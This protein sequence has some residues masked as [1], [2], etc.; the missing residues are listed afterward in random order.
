VYTIFFVRELSQ[1]FQCSCFYYTSR[2][3][4][5][6]KYQTANEPLIEQ[7]SL[8]RYSYFEHFIGKVILLARPGTAPDC[9]EPREDS[10]WRS[11]YRAH[12]LLLSSTANVSLTHI[13]TLLCSFLSFPFRADCLLL[14]VKCVS[15]L[16]KV[17]PVAKSMCAEVQIYF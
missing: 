10:C 5:H 15:V 17:R 3:R 11:H 6:I 4:A 7:C 9:I 16:V 12:E 2:S 14:L 1:V 8:W 13:L